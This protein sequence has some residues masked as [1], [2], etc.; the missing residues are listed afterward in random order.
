MVNTVDTSRVLKDA[1][2]AFRDDAMAG[3]LHSGKVIRDAR[4]RD[5]TV[6]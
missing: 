4:S 2:E 3:K 5:R 6:H 1:S